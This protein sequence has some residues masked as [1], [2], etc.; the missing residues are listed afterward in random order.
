MWLLALI[1]WCVLRQPTRE[2]VIRLIRAFMA[3]QIVL[4]VGLMLLYIAGLVIGLHSLG[5]WMPSH[6]TI[7]I[8]WMISVALVSLVNINSITEDEHYFRKAALDQIKLLV[9]FEF[10]INFYVLSLWLELAIVPVVAFLGG[11]LAVAES[12]R[13]YKPVKTIL[14]WLFAI[15][16]T[17]L[18]S[19]SLYQAVANLDTFATSTTLKDLAVPSLMSLAFLPF[20]YIMALFVS[21]ESLF[22]RLR[23]FIKDDKLVRFTKVRT[24]F[25]FNV[26]LTL[27]N[28]WACEINQHSFENREDILGAIRDFRRGQEMPLR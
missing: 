7:T 8:F 13:Q 10:I 18:M 25:A 1:A 22:K 20:L 16:G 2:A 21:Y 28:K 14:D 12:N 5:V 19:W 17:V 11:M 4:S 9:L 27:L 24:L 15:L 26:R 23:F 6:A 3:R